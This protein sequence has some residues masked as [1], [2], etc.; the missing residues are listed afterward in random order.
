MAVGALASDA[1]TADAPAAWAGVLAAA[2]CDAA[3][4]DAAL[5]GALL[6]AA[7]CDAAGAEAG[8]DA[9]AAEAAEAA[10]TPKNFC[11]Q[12]SDTW[13]T[14]FCSF[15]GIFSGLSMASALSH[16]ALSP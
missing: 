5:A 14:V 10:L 2:G 6:F 16:W 12:L 1:A 8:A 13:A 15:S 3:A 4:G 9:M 11:E 7:G